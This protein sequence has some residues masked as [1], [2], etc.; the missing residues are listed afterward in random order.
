M[1]VATT[2][3]GM[4]GRC[5]NDMPIPSADSVTAGIIAIYLASMHHLFVIG[6]I[7]SIVFA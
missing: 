3:D 7:V 5:I 1:G 2:Y 6:G 4:M